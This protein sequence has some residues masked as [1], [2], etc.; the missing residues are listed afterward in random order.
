MVVLG[1]YRKEII[2]GVTSIQS[3]GVGFAGGLIVE[4]LIFQVA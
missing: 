3:E 1:I 2:K 4:E